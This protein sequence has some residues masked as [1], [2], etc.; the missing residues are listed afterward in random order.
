MNA[1]VHGRGRVCVCVRVR[2]CVCVRV[3]VCVC[4]CVR[5]RGWVGVLVC[6]YV[7]ACARARV[8]VCMYVCVS[9]H[10]KDEAVILLIFKKNLYAWLILMFCLMVNAQYEWS[11]TKTNFCVYFNVTGE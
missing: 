5:A 1:R 10:C 3:F 6:A 11:V 7:R 9:L 2:L 4:V 8:R